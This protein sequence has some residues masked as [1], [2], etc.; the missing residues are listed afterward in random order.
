MPYRSTLF[1]WPG[2]SGQPHD[3]VLAVPC[4]DPTW[5]R[6]ATLDDLSKQLQDEIA[7]FFSVYKDLEQKAVKVRGWFSREDALEEIE[8]SRERYRHGAG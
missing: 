4:T 3:K 2:K 7:H 8:A 5:N 1:V 6:L